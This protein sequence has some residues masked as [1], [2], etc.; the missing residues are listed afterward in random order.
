MIA[1][2]LCSTLKLVQLPEAFEQEL[3]DEEDANQAHALPQKTRG[4]AL[5]RSEFLS[6]WVPT[7]LN[8]YLVLI[9]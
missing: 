8:S 4:L 7:I 6:R 9:P 2:T 5:Q 1:P 3:S